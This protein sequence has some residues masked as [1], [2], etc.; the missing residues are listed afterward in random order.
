MRR[1]LSRWFDRL[2]EPRVEWP[3]EY[4][5]THPIARPR[6]HGR[7]GDPARAGQQYS[8]RGYELHWRADRPLSS[9]CG[10]CFPQFAC[11]DLIKTVGKIQGDIF[12]DE[13]RARAS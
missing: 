10:S 4:P 12:V 9:P 13:G 6:E 1:I 7:S 8:F 2:R 11:L 5:A 3:G